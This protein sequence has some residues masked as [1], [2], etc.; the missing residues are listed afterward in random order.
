MPPQ[1]R[2]NPKPPKPPRP[3]QWQWHS[4]SAGGDSDDRLLEAARAGGEAAFAR[5]LARHR[6]W[7]RRLIQAVVLDPDQAE[8]LTQEAF[9]RVYQHLASYN[10]RERF[11]PW[12][13]Q[14]A[15]NLARNALRDRKVRDAL[16]ERHALEERD[17]PDELA[18]PQHVLSSRLLQEEV[19]SALEHLAP[20]QRE[21]LTL[22]YFAGLSIEEIA[23]QTGIPPGTV[24]SRLFHARRLVRQALAPSHIEQVTPNTEGANRNE[25]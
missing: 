11:V 10:A 21:A 19:R 13:K 16:L 23:S 20:E 14:I 9:C 3:P 1:P 8:D 2:S 15:L 7:V 18:D 25:R 17:R 4:G 24:K 22:H 5:L 6:P 12:L